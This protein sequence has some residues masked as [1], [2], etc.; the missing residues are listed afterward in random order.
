MCKYTKKC[1]IFRYNIEKY[2][3]MNYIFLGK[4]SY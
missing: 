4:K 3:I 2:N 1:N